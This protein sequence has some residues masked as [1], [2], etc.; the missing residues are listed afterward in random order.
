MKYVTT[1]VLAILALA[2]FHS[3]ASA[4]GGWRSWD[5]YL[6]D[7][8]QLEA[9]PLRITDA[10]KFIRG[11]GKD[12][13]IDRSKIAYLAIS[14]R[15]LPPMPDADPSKDMVVLLDG[16]HTLGPVRFRNFKFSEGVILQNGK[17][18]TTENVA[19]IRF[20]RRKK[21]KSGTEP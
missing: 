7:G 13:G 3:T 4:Q 11:M 17:E 15:E 18:I 1:G 10:G 12:P 6:L 9:N 5:I 20:G 14:R 2:A 21:K 8:T 19:Y 16:S